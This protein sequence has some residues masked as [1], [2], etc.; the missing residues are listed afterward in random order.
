SSPR[1]CIWFTW[2]AMSGA[3]SHSLRYFY[4]AVSEPGQGLPQFIAVGYVDDQPITHYDSNT[5]KDLPRVPWMGKV[6][7]DDPQYWQWNT[8]AARNSEQVFRENLVIAQKYYNQS[9][10]LHTLQLMYGCELRS[11]GSKGGYEQFGYDGWDYISFDKE[12]RTWTAADATAQITKRKWEAE[13]AMAQRSKAY[14]E[15]TCIEWLRRYLG[16]G[17]ET[18]QQ[19]RGVWGGRRCLGGAS[20]ADL[21][22]REGT[23]GRRRSF[24]SPGPNNI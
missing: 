1:S 19:R 22:G 20:A 14:L 3:S 10:G 2:G 18:L 11:D 24:R 7:A 9:G 12:T 8:Q 6:D 16:Y 21:R 5:R 4:T 17:K 23:Y 15:E 13:P